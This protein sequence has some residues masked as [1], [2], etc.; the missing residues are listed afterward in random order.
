MERQFVSQGKASLF[1]GGRK[2]LEDCVGAGWLEACACKIGKDGRP[3]LKLYPFD[4]VQLARARIRNGTYPQ[5]V[6]T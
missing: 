4:D 6:S 3:S 5:T 1:L 2:V